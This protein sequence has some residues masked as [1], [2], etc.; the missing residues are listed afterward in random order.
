MLLAVL[1]AALGCSANGAPLQGTSIDSGTPVPVAP[2]SGQGSQEQVTTKICQQQQVEVSLNKCGEFYSTYPTGF[3][4]DAATEI[5]D[6][7]GEHI[8]S[9]GGNR[10]FTS[11]EARAEAARK[12]AAYLV[13]CTRVV[14]SCRSAR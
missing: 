3:V 9:C 1:C 6:K 5:F 13:G 14:E 4:V 10:F 7:N 2:T 8:D 11:D 12:C